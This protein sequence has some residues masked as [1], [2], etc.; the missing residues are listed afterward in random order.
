MYEQTLTHWP[1]CELRRTSHLKW[2]ICW[3]VYLGL[4][5]MK[6][7]LDSL[8]FSKRSKLQ[9]TMPKS[10]FCPQKMLAYKVAHT[11]N[12]QF[13]RRAHY[14]L[15]YVTCFWNDMS[16][17]FILYPFNRTHYKQIFGS[18]IWRCLQ[19][20]FLDKCVNFWKDGCI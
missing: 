7:M 1:K 17:L 18:K 4:S 19:T 9:T 8:H 16:L 5:Q 3:I 13:C 20:H 12:L 14:Q 15:S 11:S 6:Q 10:F 2:N